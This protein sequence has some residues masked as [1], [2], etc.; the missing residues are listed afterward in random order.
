MVNSRGGEEEDTGRCSRVPPRARGQRGKGRGR[1]RGQGALRVDD[2]ARAPCS[3]EEGR[4][5][6][7]GQRQA[8]RQLLTISLDHHPSGHRFGPHLYDGR[9]L[10]LMAWFASNIRLLEWLWPGFLPDLRNSDEIL[11][12]SDY[13]GQAAQYDYETIVFVLANA[14]HLGAWASAV[15]ATRA[16]YLR[17]RRRMAYSKLGDRRRARALPAFLDAA[18]YIPGLLVCVLK[19]KKL[20]P[21]CA[22]DAARYPG[23]HPGELERAHLIAH[24][25]GFFLGG[26]SAPLQNVSWVTDDD[27]MAANAERQKQLLNLFARTSSR[28]LASGL[29]HLK[30]GTTGMV[31]D[32]SRVFEDFVAV[33]DLA[34]GAVAE[35]YTHLGGTAAMPRDVIVPPPSTLVPK[36]RCILDWFSDATQPLRRLVYALDPTESGAG[37]RFTPLRFRGTGDPY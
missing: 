11:I 28:Y 26:L 6:A 8:G 4:G 31:D 9:E 17:D 10:G 34:A 7:L 35:C 27:S 24:L 16:R 32:T 15:T 12:G 19:S 29:G 30:V 25:I 21:L 20:P 13:G 18:N 22:V 23:W 33:P 1:P 37:I 3:S 5:R 2:A 14:R 36:A